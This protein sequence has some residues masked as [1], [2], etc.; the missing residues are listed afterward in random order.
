MIG[1]KSKFP[2]Y[3]ATSLLHE[4]WA[5]NDSWPVLETQ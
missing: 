2:S 4:L 3:T 5:V 1:V